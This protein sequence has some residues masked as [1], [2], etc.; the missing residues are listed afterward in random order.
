MKVIAASFFVFI[1]AFLFFPSA[2]SAASQEVEPEVSGSGPANV[3]YLY[4]ALGRRVAKQITI[5]G[6]PTFTE[7]YVYVGDTNKL[8]L[9]KKGNGNIITYIDGDGPN[10]H[11]AEVSSTT[12]KTY[13]T[14]HVGSVLNADPAGPYHTFGL[15][16]EVTGRV[17]LS[18]DSDPVMYG[19]QG[20]PYDAESGLWNNNAREYD[21]NTGRFL[22]AD[23]TGLAGGSTNLYMS[24]NNNPLIYTD[25]TGNGPLSTTACLT[26]AGT[27]GLSAIVVNG[28]LAGYRE[29]GAYQQISAL[30]D[31]LKSCPDGDSNQKTAI[32][33]QISALQSQ[34]N[35]DRLT[36][37]GYFTTEAALTAGLL[38]VCGITLASPL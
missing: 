26:V 28:V 38:K 14:D 25:P 11:L 32:Q 24:R 10:E 2:R 9:A 21:P 4:D 20:L 16:G 5:P 12:S 8:L 37:A 34:L 27:L 1:S 33:N 23:P 29:Y 19:W 30:Q 35:K 18:P 13:V 22:T 31:Q 15:N 3:N 36:Q 7:T 17:K 6:L